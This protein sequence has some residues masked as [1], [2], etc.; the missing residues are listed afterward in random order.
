MQTT[1]LVEYSA[2][3]VFGLSKRWQTAFAFESGE[4]A[5]ERPLGQR[6]ARVALEQRDQRR[7]SDLDD[8][9]VRIAAGERAVDV[10]PEAAEHAEQARLPHPQLPRRSAAL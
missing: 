8:R 9:V 5:R 3:L 2:L 7:E 1:E 4:R 10:D 6:L